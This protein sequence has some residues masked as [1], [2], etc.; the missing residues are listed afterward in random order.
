MMMDK[1]NR[2]AF[3]KSAG[4]V[5]LAVAAAGVLTACGDEPVPAP[6][7][8]PA[9][10]PTPIQP[11]KPEENAAGIDISDVIVT[12]GR[13]EKSDHST[14]YYAFFRFTAKNT[15]EATITLNS[16]SFTVKLD[17]G[18]EKTVNSIYNQEQNGHLVSFDEKAVDAGSSVQIA[19]NIVIDKETYDSW[20]SKSR[21]VEL[22]AHNDGKTASFTLQ[23]K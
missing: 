23:T 10:K 16:Y 21:K 20:N 5:A 7:P 11:A 4:T 12:N 2:R 14:E 19:V 3:L 13:M 22:I 8:T 15:S 1:M 18:A 6:A 9:Y 17:D